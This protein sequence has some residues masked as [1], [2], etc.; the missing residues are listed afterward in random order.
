MCL[1]I[2]AR[3]DRGSAV[4]QQLLLRM[5]KSSTVNGALTS[6]DNLTQ[7]LDKLIAPAPDQRMSGFPNI[8]DL[9]GLQKSL[10]GQLWT[11]TASH[12]SMMLRLLRQYIN[13]QLLPKTTQ[14]VSIAQL[15]LE[16][17]VRKVGRWTF[18]SPISYG[19]MYMYV[20]WSAVHSHG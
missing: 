1:C 15:G 19:A 3:L 8:S 9:K 2:Y 16:V 10:H 17:D 11:Q 13:L 7:L 18:L 14:L 5:S 4:G 20:W 12:S 6:R